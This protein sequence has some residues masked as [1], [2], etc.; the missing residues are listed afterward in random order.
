[1]NITRFESVVVRSSLESLQIAGILE[2]FHEK[3][4]TTDV[5]VAVTPAPPDGYT[6]VR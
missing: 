3:L 1:M 5:E 6:F 2:S 4:G